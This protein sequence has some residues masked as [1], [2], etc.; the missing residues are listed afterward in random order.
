MKKLLLL[1]VLLFIA[2]LSGLMAQTVELTGFGGYVFPAR[3]SSSYGSLYFNGNAMYGGSLN[4]GVS[5]V[6]DV[7]FS[8]TRIDTQ[9]EPEVVGS[10]YSFS[11]YQV[12]ENFYMLGVT[13][14]FRINKV[15]SPFVR[16]N[17]G[18][19]YLSPKESQ[20]YSYW[21]F[22]MGADAGVKVYF[23]KVI[24]LMVQA[25]LMMPVQYG[26]FYFYGGTGGGGSGVYM[27]GTLVDFGFTGGLIFRIGKQRN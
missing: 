26:G 6:V 8:Y 15:A 18:G 27:S 5:R 2:G 11:N 3:W 17:L 25:Q 21:F 13:K 1:F 23:S 4:V 10:D 19:V 14:N 22:A 12:S 20:Y 7:G 16:L 24:G 9:V